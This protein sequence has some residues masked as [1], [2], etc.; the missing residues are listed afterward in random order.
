MQESDGQPLHKGIYFNLAGLS[1]DCTEEVI[2]TMAKALSGEN[3]EKPDIWAQHESPYV[4]ALVELFSSRGLMR[5]SKVKEQL[6]AWMNGKNTVGGPL[7][8]KPHFGPSGS[9]LE[10]V[11]IYLEAIPPSEFSIDDWALLVDYL[12][13]RWMPAE[14]LATEAEWLA[15]RSVFMGKVQANIAGLSPHKAEAVLAHSSRPIW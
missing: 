2:E 1:C 14:S 5:L 8:P 12:V 13:A 10:L 15:V 11:K 3:G 7:Q 9:E 6:D 4:Q